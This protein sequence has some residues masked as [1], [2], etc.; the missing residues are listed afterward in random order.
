M[1]DLRSLHRSDGQLAGDQCS[2]DGGQ[3]ADPT[4]HPRGHMRETTSGE[5]ESH[6]LHGEYP[7]Q[8]PQPIE[9]GRLHRGVT[10]SVGTR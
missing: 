8:T 7:G 6:H 2:G 3:S 5:S 9:V 10:P 4:R 1:G